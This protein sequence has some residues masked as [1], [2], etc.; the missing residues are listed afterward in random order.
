MTNHGASVL[1][2]NMKTPDFPNL[3]TSGPPSWPRTSLEGWTTGMLWTEE[4]LALEPF[5]QK[6]LSTNQR[7][8]ENGR[9]SSHLVAQFQHLGVVTVPG[10]VLSCNIRIGRERGFPTPEKP[11]GVAD[12]PC[13]HKLHSNPTKSSFPFNFL[14]TCEV[15]SHH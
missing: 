15:K 13:S 10:P 5:L 12:S 1:G 9:L 3:P 2:E 4:I 7:A 11:S 8:V 6:L 14:E